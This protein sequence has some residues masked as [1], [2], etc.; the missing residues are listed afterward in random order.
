MEISYLPDWLFETEWCIWRVCRACRAVTSR[1]CGAR[2]PVQRWRETPPP[3][4]SRGPVGCEGMCGLYVGKKKEDL[5]ETRQ[6]KRTSKQPGTY[7]RSHSESEWSEWAEPT[8]VPPVL[9]IRV[10]EDVG[11]ECV[12]RH[13]TG[14]QR[15]S[16]RAGRG[17][18]RHLLLHCTSYALG[19]YSQVGG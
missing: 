14:P 15:H 2:R 8:D 10:M 19:A 16:P 11:A 18:K 12:M 9:F 17:H 6:D 13:S 5:I 3:S 7:S 4:S 1:G